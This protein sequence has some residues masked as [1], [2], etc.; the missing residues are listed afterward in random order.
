MKKLSA[1]LVIGSAVLGLAACSSPSDDA[2]AAATKPP[3]A[4]AATKPPAA[5]EPIPSPTARPEHITLSVTNATVKG[6][7]ADIITVNGW[8]AY[9]FEADDSKPS[10]VNCLYD[11]LVTWP[12]VLT[13]GSKVEV[14]GLDRA[15]VG[16]VKR[17]DGFE[18]VTLNGWP[19]YKFKE[20]RVK[21]DTKGEGVGGNWSAVKPD[22]KPV[23]PKKSGGNGPLG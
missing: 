10:K 13:D 18:Q 22:G 3:A 14:S 16:T 7:T 9:R 12:P 8:T 23:I 2:P 20:D 5:A 19:L 15:L 21:T 17:A 6:V 1:F 4:T 11:C